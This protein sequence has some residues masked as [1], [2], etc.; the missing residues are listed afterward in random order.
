M[1]DKQD[2]VEARRRLGRLDGAFFSGFLGVERLRG[3]GLAGKRS[4]ILTSRL[5][6]AGA[7][8]GC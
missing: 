7:G 4:A 2:A 1:K 5:L 6:L 8:F 3:R